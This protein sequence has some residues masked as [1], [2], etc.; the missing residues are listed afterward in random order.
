MTPDECVDLKPLLADR[1]TA[2][3][4]VHTNARELSQRGEQ[5]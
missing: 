5:H 3:A 2:A 4:S 1:T